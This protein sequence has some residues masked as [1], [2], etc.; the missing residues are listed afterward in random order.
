[1]GAGFQWCAVDH[2]VFVRGCNDGS[3]VLAVYVDDFLL[4]G[5]DIVGISKTKEYL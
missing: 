1:M 5:S 2:F 3:V 4:T